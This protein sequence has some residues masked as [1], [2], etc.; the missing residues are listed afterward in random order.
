MNKDH[1]GSIVLAVN[2]DRSGTMKC[3]ESVKWIGIIA[4]IAAIY[5]FVSM[6]PDM[7]RYIKLERM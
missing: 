7:R 2:Q 3:P 6:L 4:G 5:G 1:S